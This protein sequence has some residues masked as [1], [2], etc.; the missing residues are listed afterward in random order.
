MK[1]IKN[2]ARKD[3]AERKWIFVENDKF[4]IP[5][6]RNDEVYIVFDDVSDD[7][8]GCDYEFLGIFTTKERLLKALERYCKTEGQIA[9]RIICAR[10]NVYY[11]PKRDLYAERYVGGYTE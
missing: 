8:Y 5:E 9:T 11:N 3:K 2:M 1:A 6:K 10:V 4:Y 7:C